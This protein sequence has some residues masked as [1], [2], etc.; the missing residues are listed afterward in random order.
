[1]YGDAAVTAIACS[2]PTGFVPDT[3]DCDDTSAA[4]N[5]AAT[6]VCDGVDDDCS[7]VIDD[8]YAADAPTWYSDTDA[9]GYGDAAVT[10]IACSQPT[11]FVPDTTDC[12]DTS[13]A[14][15]PAATEAC[16]G[17]DDDCDGTVD[18]AGASGEAT[19]YAD[20]DADGYGNPLIT[21][22]A[23]SQP[24]GFV[25]DATDCD[26]TDAAVNPGADELCN[27]VDDDCDGDVDEDDATDATTWYPDADGDGYGDS[28]S[29]APACAAPSGTLSDGSDCDD[30]DAAIH[31]TATELCDGIDDDCDGTTDD[32]CLDCDLF[33]A[34]DGSAAYTTIQG[35]IH[36]AVD[37]EGICVAAGTYYE[38]LDLLG[39]AVTVLGLDG[40]ADTVVDG[41]GAGSVVTITSGEQSDTVLQGFTLTNG[42]APNG[43]GVLVDG[44]SPTLTDLII[45]ANRAWSYGGGLYLESRQTQA[46][47]VV[48]SDNQAA[49]GGGLAL[50][51]CGS[52]LDLTGFTVSDNTAT[53]TGGGVYLE[54]SESALTDSTVSGNA[55]AVYGGGIYV[56]EGA[57]ELSAV[58][59]DDN[60]VTLDGGG[61]FLWGG[62][63]VLQDLTLR[64]N[65]AGRYGGGAYC[66][67]T[68]SDLTGLLVSSNQASTHGGGIYLINF[69]GDLTDS[70]VYDNTATSEGG[71]VAVMGGSASL[72]RVWLLDN[73]AW[74]FGGGLALDAYATATLDDVLI[75]GNEVDGWGGGVLVYRESNLVAR[76]TRIT[77]NVA[78]CGWTPASGGGVYAVGGSL[79]LT[80]VIVAGN[81][82]QYAAGGLLLYD[83]DA[84]LDH[85]TVVGNE[86]FGSG[87]GGGVEV[88]W[89][90]VATLTNSL[91]S[92]NTSG[93]PGG[94]IHVPTTG[95]P[96]WDG[97]IAVSYSSV[98][99]N[100]PDQIDGRTS[101]TS[102]VDASQPS[103]Q[104]Y[105]AIT[106]PA[107]WDLHLDSSSSCG[108][109]DASD[110][111]ATDS[112]DLGDRGAYGGEDADDWDLDGDGWV[113]WWHPGAY[114]SAD[115]A[116]ELDCDDHDRFPR[117]DWLCATLMDGEYSLAGADVKLLGEAAGDQAGY[118]VAS[119]GDVNGDG[120]DDLLVAALYEDS[121][122]T[123]AGAA[124]LVLGPATGT[125]N[126]SG[127]EAKIVT[128]DFSHLG[129]VSTVSGVGDVNS[130]GFDD[131]LVGYP[132][133]TS[134]FLG[135]VSGDLD[136]SAADGTLWGGG[137]RVATGDADGD[138]RDDILVGDAPNAYLMVAPQVG[139]TILQLSSTATFESEV[140]GSTY[141][142]LA[143][144]LGDVDGDGMDDL[145]FGDALESSSAENAGAAYLVLS[146]TSGTMSLAA[147]DTKLVGENADDDAGGSVSSAGDVDGDGLADLLVGAPGAGTAYL[148]LGPA[149]VSGGLAGAHATLV[150]SYAGQSVAP[151][152]DMDADGFDDVIIGAGGTSAD[153]GT[154]Y[155]VLGPWSGARS[156]SEADVVLT[157][158]ASGDL[159]GCSVASAGD[160]DGDGRVDLLIGAY[161]EDSAGAQAGAAYLLFSGL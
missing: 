25:P 130:D 158:E 100:S 34:A 17:Y 40:A 122:D 38:N 109:D 132:G 139:T 29:G 102:H 33:V 143:V 7:G 76:N 37:G 59:I 120:L 104:D 42:L 121:G 111:D 67:G 73:T 159:A 125:S 81:T 90:T 150:G 87:G 68:A 127:A 31:P 105:D 77:G 154:A 23:C 82:A 47:D 63:P 49:N 11:G 157:G 55:A 123:D 51:L 156:A 147:S 117:P 2:Q 80:N 13:A 10:A 97:T 108:I 45:T 61:L 112:S 69:T 30:G 1:G 138:G 21:D 15:N 116:A 85:L 134:M 14:V 83:V 36:D 84:T 89:F 26:D 44:A 133:R 144:S 155:L 88:S 119:A 43:G 32:D 118:S 94:G 151:A 79:D 53:S 93:A 71:G 136:L 161:G 3:T 20:A 12:D 28:S 27:G 9:D 75:D 142:Y 24:T 4:V 96:T 74:D 98:G 128:D 19:W 160:V 22:I 131:I 113:D 135:P 114:D 64:G 52:A 110:Y 6:E 107:T 39:R 99:G 41:G 145:M 152:G 146:P 106:D 65:D 57:P 92:D 66:G 78:D 91:V 137:L 54:D 72:S 103:Y 70:V 16:N 126:L 149:S 153:P 56:S 101:S 95:D 86:A 60:D 35:A 18:E 140:E 62:T 50:M 8:D 115:L 48:V 46:R 129:G 5:P 141:A 58:E 124:Y 148:V